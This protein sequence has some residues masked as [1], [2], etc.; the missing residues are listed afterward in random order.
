MV[1]V[2][3][4]YLIITSIWCW[5]M[6][7]SIVSIFRS[8]NFLGSGKSSL[9]R[10][11]CGLW[12]ADSGKCN[13]LWISCY[14]QACGGCGST[15]LGVR[16]DS[17][18]SDVLPPLRSW[19]RVLYRISDRTWEEFVNTLPKVVGFLRVLRFSSSHRESWQGGLG[20]WCEKPPRGV[21]WITYICICL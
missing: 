14:S 4:V 5:N 11:M 12:Q 8:S 1:S 2:E 19:V 7:S 6:V 10:I 17:G 21:S 15:T 9:L 18:L 20:T 16:R 3:L 13:M